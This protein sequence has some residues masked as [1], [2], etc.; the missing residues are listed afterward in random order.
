M[1]ENKEN[2]TLLNLLPKE[3]KKVGDF[4]LLEK[5]YDVSVESDSQFVEA[6]KSVGE[7]HVKNSSFYKKLVEKSGIDIKKIQTVEDCL[8]FPAIW[9]HYFKQS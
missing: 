5:P 8:N 6:M 1:A 4:C 2:E 7:Y 9:A 3:L